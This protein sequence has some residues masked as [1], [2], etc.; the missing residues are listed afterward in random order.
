MGHLHHLSGCYLVVGEAR[1]AFTGHRQFFYFL[2]SYGTPPFLIP[3]LEFR[4]LPDQCQGGGG[5]LMAHVN[6]FG[7]HLSKW[8]NSSLQGSASSFSFLIQNMRSLY[9]HNKIVPLHFK[10][11]Y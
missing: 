8:C 3:S 10:S 11:G 2:N 6:D 7:G 4:L 9:F 1:S 5:T